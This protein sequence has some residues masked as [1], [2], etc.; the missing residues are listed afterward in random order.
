M[1]NKWTEEKWYG[2]LTFRNDLVTESFN[3]SGGACQT[4]RLTTIIETVL[5]S[6]SGEKEIIESLEKPM[7]GR[8]QFDKNGNYRIEKPNVVAIGYYELPEI[9][10]GFPYDAERNAYMMDGIPLVQMA[11]EHVHL[12]NQLP[13]TDFKIATAMALVLRKTM[14]KP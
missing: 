6:E 8:F 9:L 2:G 1:K 3:T 4:C 5:I 13:E 12:L 10:N 11:T 7:F 14:K